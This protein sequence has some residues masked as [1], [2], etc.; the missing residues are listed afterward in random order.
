M[1][2]RFFVPRKGFW[3]RCMELMWVPQ[4]SSFGP[5]LE[6]KWSLSGECRCGNLRKQQDHVEIN[7][8][9]WV[10]SFRL[11]LTSWQ[12]DCNWFFLLPLYGYL[13]LCAVAWQIC[14]T[15]CVSCGETAHLC[16][17]FPRQMSVNCKMFVP[18][19]SPLP[20]TSLSSVLGGWDMGMAPGG[21]LRTETDGDWQHS[22]WLGWL[23]WR[24][25][26]RTK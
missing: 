11:H 12:N 25:R 26:H 3:K 22:G 6:P 23:V 17:T 8:R 9:C 1:E 14:W 15:Y 13:T 20:Y 4:P 2:V 5:S 24:L 16:M 19:I 18:H 7:D 10:Y 21:Q